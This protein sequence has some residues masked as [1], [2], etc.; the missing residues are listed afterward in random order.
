MRKIFTITRKS[1]SL[2]KQF[3]F[4]SFVSLL[5]LFVLYTQAVLNSRS[6]IRKRNNVKRLFKGEAYRLTGYG[7]AYK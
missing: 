7:I 5:S 3:A 2:C 1:L 4:A 6:W